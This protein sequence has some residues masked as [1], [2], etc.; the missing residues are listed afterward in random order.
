M[1]VQA[2][3]R[4]L[5][6]MTIA[7]AALVFAACGSAAPP[8]VPPSD[9]ASYPALRDGGYASTT[10]SA[11][12][13]VPR[14]WLRAWLRDTGALTRNLEST[15]AIARPMEAEV[16]E[17]EWYE[18][19][20]FRRLTL[21]DGHYVLER[22]V[23]TTPERLE[24]QIWAFTNTAGRN[25]DHIQGIQTFSEVG[26]EA[27]GDRTAFTW[28]YAAF[29]DAGFKR[30]FVQRFVNREVRP[31]LQASLDA[32]VAEAEAAFRAE[33]AGEPDRESAGESAP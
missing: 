12:F 6:A 7:G 11:E 20:S 29:P 10:L 33:R 25:L 13:A 14:P 22:I 9:T 26:D 23:D 2:R 27:G 30:P 5:M 18:P 19:G 24:Y 21:E 4:P 1:R 8:A 28:T 32:T 16:L 31:Y 17:G 3:L 15:D